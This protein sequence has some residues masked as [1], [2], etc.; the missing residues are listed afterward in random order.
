MYM[1]KKKSINDV[2]EWKKE[3]KYKSVHFVL[4]FIVELYKIFHKFHQF[5]SFLQ[6]L[7]SIVYL[8][9]FLIYR[10]AVG[11]WVAK[12]IVRTGPFEITWRHKRNCFMCWGL[13]MKHNLNEILLSIFLFLKVI[14]TNSG[15]KLLVGIRYK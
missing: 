1:R 9:F 4:K 15:V 12:S 6:G 11:I 7:I 8:F 3:Q 5:Y 2:T 13:K 14:F 10:G